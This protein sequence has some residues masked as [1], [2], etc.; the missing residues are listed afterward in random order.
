MHAGVAADMF[1]SVVLAAS[2]I[3]DAITAEVSQVLGRNVPA[4]NIDAYPPLALAEP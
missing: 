3:F 4:R 1:D 2:A